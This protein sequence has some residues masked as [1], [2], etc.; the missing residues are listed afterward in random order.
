MS[1]IVFGIK[2]LNRVHTAK[3]F[4]EVITKFGCSIKT[5]IGLHEVENGVCSPAGIILIEFIGDDAAEFEKELLALGEI[6]VQK[7]TF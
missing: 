6:E 4:Q 1:I 2:L 7:M 3:D 5:R